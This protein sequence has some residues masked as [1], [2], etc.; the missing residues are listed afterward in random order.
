MPGEFR[1]SQN[2]IGGSSPGNASFVPPSHENVPAL[3]S[4]LERFAHNEALHLPPLLKVAL[5]HYQFETIHPFL[6]GNGRMGR[7]MITLYLV[8]LGILKKPVLYLSAYLERNRSTYYEHLTNV[9]EHDTIDDWLL[10]FLDGI[11]E[12]AK[13]GVRTFDQILNFQKD[14]E[15]TIQSWTQHRT[16]GIALFRHLFQH[17]AL[18]AQSV[19]KAV[20][21]SAPTAYKLVEYFVEQGILREITGAKRG[22]LY[23]FDPYLKLYRA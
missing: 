10:F 8:S 1:S 15:Q 4:D 22:K 23:L 3:M 14:W 19:A 5:M 6:D 7:L 18:N 16:N 13:Q 17:P 2:W 12:T 20:G 9:R 11:A 21:V